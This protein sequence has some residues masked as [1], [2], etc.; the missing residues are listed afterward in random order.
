MS[1]SNPL[2]WNES[3]CYRQLELTKTD[4]KTVVWSVIGSYKVLRT[5]TGTALNGNHLWSIKRE[6]IPLILFDF[7]GKSEITIENKL[8]IPAHRYTYTH[9][10]EHEASTGQN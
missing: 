9:E 5:R 7:L 1:A 6:L 8:T 2:H 10:V 4:F 3:A